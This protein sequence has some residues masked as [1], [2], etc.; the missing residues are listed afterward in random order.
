MD[1]LIIIKYLLKVKKNDDNMMFPMNETLF[2]HLYE[3]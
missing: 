2:N 1:I 3:W